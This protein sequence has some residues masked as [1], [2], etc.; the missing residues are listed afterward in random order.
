MTTYSSWGLPDR[1]E[2]TAIRP[3][4]RPGD[5][6]QFSSSELNDSNSVLAYGNGRSYG[7]SCLNKQGS[8]I[9]CRSLN[10]FISFDSLSGQ[11]SVEC[12]VLFDDIINN[13]VPKGWFLPV[14]PGTRFVTVGGAIANDVHG[15]NHH[16]N[17]TLGRHIL[18]L[19]LLRSDGQSLTCSPNGN[20]ELF[21]ATIGGLGLTGMITSATI[22]LTPIQTA[23]MDVLTVTF[24]SLQEF[25]DLS[26]QHDL[27]FEYSVAWLDC[28]SVG[29]GSFRGLLYFANHSKSL[30]SDVLNSFR[31]KPARLAVPFDIPGW[32]LNRQSV[33]LFNRYYFESGRRKS[34]N[35][36]QALQPY[37]YPLDGINNWNRIYGRSGFF[38]YQFTI[39]ESRHSTFERILKLLAERAMPSFLAV[40]KL[41]GDQPSPGILSFPKPGICLA[42]DIK[43][44]GPKTLKMLDDLDREVVEAGGSVY[45]AKDR[46]MSGD[47][48]RAFYPQYQQFSEY[49]DPAIS[50]DLWRRVIQ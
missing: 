42:L 23:N 11:L 48:F 5:L 46:R 35:S 28:L 15:K 40:L 39:P 16:R 7:D 38:Q 12:G 1:G 47:A 27:E 2:Q 22:Q 25:L 29:S 43:D 20:T 21:N 32:C 36:T 19:Q 4:W 30:D 10:R 33:S 17:G 49:V 50:S 45:P 34:G 37:F 13:F 8:L 9:D 18:E 3:P 44:Q 26:R 14:T 41:F 31:L 24:S 6:R